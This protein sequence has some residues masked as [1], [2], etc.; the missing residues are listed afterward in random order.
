MIFLLVVAFVIPI[1]LEVPVMVRGKSWK[2]LT[3][4]SI[5]MTLAFVICLLEILH[6]PVWNPVKDT[7]YFVSGLL[8][9]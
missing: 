6:I 2:E 8:P 5:L 7:Q 9:K 3:V 4:Y 1:W